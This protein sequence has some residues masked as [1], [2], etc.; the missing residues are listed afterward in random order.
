MKD[1]LTILTT[2]HFKASAHRINTNY[3][4]NHDRLNTTTSLIERMIQ[5][6]YTHMGSYDIKHYISLD[7]DPHDEGSCI[8]LKNLQHL[9]TIYPNLHIIVTVDGIRQSILNLVKSVQTEY[10]LYFEHDWEFVYPVDIQNL[11]NIFDHNKTIN[12]IRFNKRNNS[13]AGWDTIMKEYKFDST[14]LC[15]TNA[16]SNNPYIAR[17]D[18][19]INN[20]LPL[21]EQYSPAIP[22][23]MYIEDELMQY[24][25]NDIRS[26]GWDEAVVKWGIYIYGKLNQANTV[27]HLNGRKL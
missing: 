3:K 26:I 21:L 1:K 13:Q 14:Y 16:W 2:T 8:Y 11:I 20:W 19:W 6:L 24:Y 23:Y 25:Q 12:Y 9:T 27:N 4:I 22:K 7:H 10:F 18:N 5:S 17:T 15:A